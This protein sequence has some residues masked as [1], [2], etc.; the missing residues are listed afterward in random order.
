MSAGVLRV[1]AV[2]K[3]AFIRDALVGTCAT[4]MACRLLEVS[5]SG[6]DQFLHA[7]PVPHKERRLAIERALV[8]I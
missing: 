3:Y 4:H 1:G 2:V 8:Q 7:L 5:S 6:Y